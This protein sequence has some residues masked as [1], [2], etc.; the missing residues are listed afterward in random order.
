[1]IDGAVDQPGRLRG[2]GAVA[3]EDGEIAEARQILG[4]VAARGLEAGRHR[5][6]EA[7]VL[8]VEE[9]RQFLGG[10]DGQRRPEAPGRAGSVAAEH[11]C[12]RAFVALV[13]EDSAIISDRLRPARGRRI[14]SPDPARHGQGRRP[15]RIGIVEDDPDIAAVRIAPFPAHSGA[16]RVLDRHPERE[17]KRPRAIIAAGG[18]A[19]VGETASEQRLGHIVAA[20]GE[21]VEDLA[22][23]DEPFLLELVQRPAEL[24]DVGDPPPIIAIMWRS[25]AIPHFLCTF[26]HPSSPPPRRRRNRHCRR[27]GRRC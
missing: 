26:T 15:A 21:L 27:R 9:H 8:D 13:L 17:Q 4:D 6:S 20:R 7:I 22:L 10:G 24:D 1:M 16:E 18:V 25:L 19:A 5:D 11:Q 3:G 23:G 2:L 14:L 12:D